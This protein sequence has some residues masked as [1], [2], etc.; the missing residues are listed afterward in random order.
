M[1]L[2]PPSDPRWRPIV[3]GTRRLRFEFFALNMLLTRVRLAIANKQSGR[4]E[5]DWA[6]EVRSL[7][8]SNADLPSVQRDVQQMFGANT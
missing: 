4:T 8:E 6:T 7:L 5:L 2:P 3:Q 1:A